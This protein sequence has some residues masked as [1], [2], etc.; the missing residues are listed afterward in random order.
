MRCLSIAVVLVA[1]AAFT[2]KTSR[3]GLGLSA[4]KPAA[5]LSTATLQEE[6]V[7][8]KSL[9]NMPPKLDLKE[10]IRETHTERVLRDANDVLASLSGP[11]QPTSAETFVSQQSRR[12]TRSN[13]PS[14][15]LL[16]AEVINGLAWTDTR[17][18]REGGTQVRG[19]CI[20]TDDDVDE[21]EAKALAAGSGV[22]RPTAERK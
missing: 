14:D 19:S 3:G 13:T 22:L 5:L 21:F 17:G 6:A 1:A 9:D 16:G 4:T 7:V 10:P 11:G 8:V 15:A 12:P 2:P 20:R 18:P